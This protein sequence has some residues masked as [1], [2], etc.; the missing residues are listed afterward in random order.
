MWPVCGTAAEERGAHRRREGCRSRRM[1]ART[2][3]TGGHPG[4]RRGRR[5]LR[6]ARQ[7]GVDHGAGVSPGR[8]RRTRSLGQE[9]VEAIPSC[10]TSPTCRR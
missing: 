6:E 9:F 10:W 2:T 7:P 1:R 3:G 5:H 4:L 8:M